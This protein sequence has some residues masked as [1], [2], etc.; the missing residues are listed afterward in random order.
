MITPQGP[1][2][3]REVS[4][5][6][7]GEQDV[8]RSPG[9]PQDRFAWE[10]AHILLGEAPDIRSWEL[11]SPPAFEVQQDCI[12]ICTGGSFQESRC[13]GR[14][15]PHATV[16]ALRAGERLEWGIRAWGFRTLLALRPLSK[17]CAGWVGRERGS[18][19]QVAH[20]PGRQGT[21]RV[22]PGP[23]MKGLPDPEGFLQ[24][25]WTTSLQSSD[26]GLRLEGGGSGTYSDTLSEMVSAPV[27]DGTVQLTPGG[28]IL[29]L[30]LRPTLGGYPRVFN[31]IHPDVD[32]A[33]QI[34]PRR[35]VRF[36]RVSLNEAER[37]R[38][39]QQKDLLALRDALK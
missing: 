39:Q 8:G 12:G 28:L 13:G 11:I 31:V 16:F 9:G 18:F 27:A 33:A 30:R 21:L 5:P 25:R 7:A 36:E 10:T 20:W 22:V 19:G 6:R 2:L 32:L 4:A 3:F 14:S 34:P 1:G 29:L 26:T 24:H 15:I 37:I 23:E 35:R 17:E 38:Q